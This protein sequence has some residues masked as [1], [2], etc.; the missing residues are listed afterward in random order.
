MT[1]ARRVVLDTTTFPPSPG[2][3]RWWRVITVGPAGETT[4]EVPPARFT[5]D[6][7][8]PVRPLP[9]PTQAGPNGERVLHALRGD[10]P[11][12]FG[13]LASPNTG[14]PAAGGTRLN[15]RDQKL[16]YSLAAW[17]A[18]DFTVAVRVLIHQMP[19]GRLGQIFS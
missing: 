17:P 5:L 7:T 13:R 14:T 1:D 19:E 15:G 4:P 9:P 18:E 8:A 16:V 10:R 11:P 2:A 6:A 12:Q 3:D